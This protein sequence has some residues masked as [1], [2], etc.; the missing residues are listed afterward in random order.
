MDDHQGKF[1]SVQSAGRQGSQH[2]GRNWYE[3]LDREDLKNKTRHGL[4]ERVYA[5][6]SVTLP[7]PPNPNPKKWFECNIILTTIPT[8][9]FQ[10]TRAALSLGWGGAEIHISCPMCSPF[11]CLH[12]KI[13]N[14][15]W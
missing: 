6:L 2:G 7:P 10:R 14:D 1:L 4:F 5:G 3:L 13:D 15:A 9:W 12:I 8:V 11:S